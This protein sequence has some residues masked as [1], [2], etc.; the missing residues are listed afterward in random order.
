MRR[1]AREFRGSPHTTDVLA[2][3]YGAGE[4]IGEVAVNLD[5]ARRQAHERGVELWHELTLLCVHGLLHIAGQG[6][7]TRRDWCDMR[8]AEFETLARIL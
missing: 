2:F 6:D 5:A 4:L 1:L 3:P 8:V 7:E